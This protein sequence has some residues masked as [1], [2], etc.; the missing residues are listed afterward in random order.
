L[1]RPE[2]RNALDL[3]MWSDLLECFHAVS[4]NP[5]DRVI[6]LSGAGGAFCAG[7]DI[8][9][10]LGVAPE[11][12]PMRMQLGAEVVL[13]LHR[14]SKPTIA[15]VAGP[16]VGGGWNLALACD[17]VVAGESA[18][19]S[20]VFITI[21][22]SVDLGG[23]WILP[24]LVGL[25]RAKELAF[26]AEF[27]SAHQAAG[28]GLVNRVVP[29]GD[30]DSFVRDWARRLAAQSALP[31]SLT[32]SLMDSGIESSL[33]EALE[34]EGL[35]QTINFSAGEA[36]TALAELADRQRSASRAKPLEE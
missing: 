19:F 1:N 8:V 31:L 32:K 9:D 20:Q 30:L 23:S 22:L 3:Q 18:R 29:D 28:M 6:V 10:A 2:K 21:A 5:D 13:A 35:C 11:D 4:R 7:V 24:R 36:A 16:A 26:F 25:Q 12:W 27:L 14:I 17:L 33:E 34:R 15:K